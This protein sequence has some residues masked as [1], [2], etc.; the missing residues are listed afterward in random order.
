MAEADRPIIA[1]EATALA[2]GDPATAPSDEGTTQ[3]SD[4]PKRRWGRLVL[5]LVVPLALLVGGTVYWLSLAGKV[6]TDNAY[7]KQDKVAVSAQVGGDI[8]E[9]LVRDG[10]EVKAGSA[11]VPDRS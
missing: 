7:V 9:V 10:D 4:K 1:D 11:A 5:M 2:S 6:S 3:V 8:A